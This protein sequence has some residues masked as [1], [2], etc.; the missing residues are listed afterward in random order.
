MKLIYYLINFIFMLNL[1][2]FKE[3]L[4]KLSFLKINENLIK[5]EK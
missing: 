1:L 4:I 2:R 5:F 3:I